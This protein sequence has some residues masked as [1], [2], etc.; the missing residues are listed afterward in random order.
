MG[1]ARACKKVK[2]IKSKIMKKYIA[3]SFVA[4]V[5][6]MFSSFG[7][8]SADNEDNSTEISNSDVWE[9]MHDNVFDELNVLVNYDKKR[10]FSRCP[11]G[12]SQH[13]DA[14][15]STEDFVYGEITFAQGCSR[16]E[17]CDYKIDWNKKETFLKKE[18]QKDFVSL[19]TFVKT[20]KKKTAKI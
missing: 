10:S 1:R 7:S 19:S 20:E 17:F 5:L 14:E 2:L 11:S 15:K 18:K 8:S 13:M 12:F 9:F 16:D 3:L 6:L 4:A